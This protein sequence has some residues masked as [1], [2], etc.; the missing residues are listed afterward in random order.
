MGLPFA[1]IRPLVALITGITGG[2]LAN[3]ASKNEVKKSKKIEDKYAHLSFL[4]KIKKVFQYGFIDFIQ[5][6]SKW[7]GILFAIVLDELVNNGY[8]L[9]YFKK[10]KMKANEFKFDVDKLRDAV[11]NGGCFFKG[12]I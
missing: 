9:A 1:I 10:K 12:A 11:E 8:I 5:D 2:F 4:R 6:I 7:L 3:A